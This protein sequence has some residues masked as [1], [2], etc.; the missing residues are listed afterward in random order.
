VNAE[1]EF[2]ENFKFL[3]EHRG[4]DIDE[5]THEIHK[6]VFEEVDCLACGNC[7]RTTPA[8]LLKSDIKRIAKHL[9]LPP[10]TFIKKYTI[11]DI[12][13]EISLSSVPCMFLNEDNTCQ[14]YEIRPRACREY[15]HTDQDS[16]SSRP[17]LNAKNTIVCP[18]SFEIVNRLKQ[19]L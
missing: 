4:E 14:V 8:I 15:P 18:A 1:N 17:K 5:V 19:I 10:K 9:N 13:G 12:N 3:V 11:T 2:D 6:E 16:F 7:C